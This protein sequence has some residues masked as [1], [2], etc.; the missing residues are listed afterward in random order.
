MVHVP[1]I[2][3]RALFLQPSVEFVKETYRNFGD[4]FY[5]RL[6]CKTPCQLLACSP[7]STLV[8]ALPQQLAS[9]LPQHVVCVVFSA[10]MS[11]LMKAPI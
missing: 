1:Q 4:I 9:G 11:D 5:A 2:R 10:K 8:I 6:S 3:N 7:A